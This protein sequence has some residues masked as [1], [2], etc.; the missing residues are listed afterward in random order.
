[1]KKIKSVD[2]VRKEQRRQTVE[3]DPASFSTL[4]LGGKSGGSVLEKAAKRSDIVQYILVLAI[5]IINGI[6]IMI[7]LELPRHLQLT[8]ARCPLTLFGIDCATRALPTVPYFPRSFLKPG[9]SNSTAG[10][11]LSHPS[12]RILADLFLETVAAR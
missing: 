1:M 6:A 3:G 4:L 12:R 11:Y 8:I 10:L 5:D 7:F 9:R 2:K